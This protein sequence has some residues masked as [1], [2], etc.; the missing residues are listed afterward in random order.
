MR[1]AAA[2][3]LVLAY[4]LIP[5]GTA[6]PTQAGAIAVAVLPFD[7]LSSDPE[8]Q[9]FSD[10]ITEEITSA[11]ARIPDLGV[12]A[13]TSASQFKGQDRNIQEIARALNATHLIEGSVR[14]AGD[15]VR[16][17]AQLIQADDGLHVWTSSYERELTDIFAIQ[18]EIALAIA[19]A[20]R[21][22]LGLAP[23]QSLIA[24]RNIDPVSYEQYLSARA[25]IRSRVNQPDAVARRIAA[26]AVLEQVVARHPEYAPAWATLSLGYFR[27]GIANP[28]NRTVLETRRSV[29]EWL[30]K[31]EAAAR[32]ANELDPN[33]AD[34]YSQLA[35]TMAIK[36]ELIQAEE[37][38]SKALALDPFHPETMHF[39]AILLG[40][41]GRVKEAIA[42]RE[43][44]KT[45]DPLIGV[46]GSNYEEMLWAD[47]QSEKVAR[48]SGHFAGA[49]G[50]S[51]KDILVTATLLGRCRRRAYDSCAEWT[52]RE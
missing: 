23:G 46:Y 44:V 30:P 24:N 17:T 35:V 48:Q 25:L 5:R 9:F 2:M 40:A 33:L 6:E 32:H 20:L 49:P 7:N 36:G 47:G 52:P 21:M 38:Y 18:E 14:K 16:I 45:L 37:L 13:R 12:V 11:L 43:K 51:R 34:G 31:A 42:M 22:P 50:F 26:I 3:A 15:R 8:Q 28:G 29:D 39:Y 1:L 41:V 4:A 27:R 19:G 10:G